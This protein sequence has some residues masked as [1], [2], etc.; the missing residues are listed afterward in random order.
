MTFERCNAK[1]KAWDLK[2]FFRGVSLACAE[3]SRGNEY[4]R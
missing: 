1:T 2:S 3:L 4:K